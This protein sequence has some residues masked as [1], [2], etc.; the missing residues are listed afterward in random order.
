MGTINKGVCFLEDACHSL[1]ILLLKFKLCCFVAGIVFSNSV[2]E[3]R[4][5]LGAVSPVQ[6]I[7]HVFGR[8]NATKTL[9]FTAE[10]KR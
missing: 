8:V 7:F 6:S 1:C 2:L 10:T 4:F 5:L 3:I 9:Q